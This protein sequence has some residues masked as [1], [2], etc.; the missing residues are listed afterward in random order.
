[1]VESFPESSSVS[2]SSISETGFAADMFETNEDP[3]T[4][5]GHLVVRSDAVLLLRIT[6]Y[7]SMDV[8]IV[9]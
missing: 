8:K 9:F 6:A 3:M 4:T 2:G 7:L 1:L 5:G